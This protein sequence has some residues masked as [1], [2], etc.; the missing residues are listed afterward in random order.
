MI[1]NDPMLRRKKE[2]TVTLTLTGGGTTGLQHVELDGVRHVGG[3]VIEVAV[4]SIMYCYINGAV[5]LTLQV[6]VNGV[7]VATGDS[8]TNVEYPYTVTK[9]ATVRFAAT[10]AK[11]TIT[12]T[13]ET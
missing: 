10:P 1:Y 9:N 12:I 5:A 7:T 6:I 13:E 8:N 3:E 2:K 4:N 11:A